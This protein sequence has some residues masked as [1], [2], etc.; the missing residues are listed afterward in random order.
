MADDRFDIHK[1][2][3]RPARVRSAVA[4]LFVSAEGGQG[5]QLRVADQHLPD[6]HTPGDPSGSCE[7]S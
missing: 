5:I 4:G 7:A 1:D 6:P 3:D 2:I